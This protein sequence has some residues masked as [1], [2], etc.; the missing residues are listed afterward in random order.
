MTKKTSK[1]AK[2]METPAE[3]LNH[4]LKEFDLNPNSLARA[5]GVSQG[6][7]RLMAMDKANVTV[8]NALRLGRFFNCSPLDWINLQLTKEINEAVKDKKL[9]KSIKEIQPIAESKTNDSKKSSLKADSL[10]GKKKISTKRKAISSKRKKAA[11]VPGARTAKRKPA[12][13]LKRK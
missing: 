11:K 2:T 4:L 12:G 5:I 3:L 7:V 1:T 6:I 9:M 10:K 8:Q 13:R